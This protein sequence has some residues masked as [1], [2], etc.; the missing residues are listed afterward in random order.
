MN[1]NARLESFKLLREFLKDLEK[2]KTKIQNNYYK[3]NKLNIIL[4]D[5]IKNFKEKL[6]IY[7]NRISYIKVLNHSSSTFII[8]HAHSFSNYIKKLEN[9]HTQ[10]IN[11]CNILKKKIDNLHINITKTKLKLML[12]S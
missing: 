8:L 12:Q 3:I 7:N 6:D 9:E 5:K 1:I 10:N 4:I 2:Q 11:F